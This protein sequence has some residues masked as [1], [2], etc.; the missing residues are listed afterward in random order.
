MLPMAHKCFCEFFPPPSLHL[1]K[2]HT[3]HCVVYISLVFVSL[4]FNLNASLPFWE[5]I[6]E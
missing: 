6:K 4:F 3:L 1:T 2:T 5:I